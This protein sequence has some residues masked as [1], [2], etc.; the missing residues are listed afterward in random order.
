MYLFLSQSLNE[1]LTFLNEAPTD[2]RAL[3]GRNQNGTLGREGK[4]LGEK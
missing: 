4:R 2:C 3:C 1:T